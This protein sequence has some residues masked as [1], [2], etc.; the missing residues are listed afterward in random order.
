[1]I[2][3]KTILFSIFLTILFFLFLLSM[4]NAQAGTGENVYGWAWSS[5]IGWISFNNTSGG[6]GVNYGVNINPETNMLSGYAWSENI[7]WITFN[8]GELLGCPSVPPFTPC[9]AW[10]DPLCVTDQ[11]DI[12]GWA[13]ACSVFQSGCSGVLDSNRGGWDGWLRL[14]NTDYDYQVYV[15]S[16]VTPAEFYDWSWSDMVVGWTS[17]NCQNQASCGVSNYRVMTGAV[18]NHIPQAINLGVAQGNYCTSPGPPIFLSWEF[19]DI[20]PGDSQSAYRAQIDDNADF[21]SIEIDTGKVNNS[22]GTFA[23]LGLFHSKAYYWR[24]KIWDSEDVESAWSIGPNFTTERNYP[25][26]EFSW[27]PVPAQLNEEIYFIDESVAYDGAVIAS[28]SWTFENAEPAVSNQQNPTT[29]FSTFGLG[30]QNQV[31][32][33]VTDNYGHFC[34]ETKSVGFALPIPEWIEIHPD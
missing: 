2:D 22:S 32:L 12:F 27:S 11:C 30:N 4:E 28:W 5:N 18:I 23:P 16:G 33:I 9:L 6:G 21:S 14:A 17:F 20:D 13:R 34:P 29:I 31:N 1:M 26:P 10:I 25:T 24:I 15:D 7:G 3:K 19:F 8:Q